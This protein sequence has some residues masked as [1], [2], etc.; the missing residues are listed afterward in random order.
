[1]A[2][3]G[4]QAEQTLQVDWDLVEERV[5]SRLPSDYKRLVEQFGKGTFD[6]G[7]IDLPL[8][9]ELVT[10]ARFH[11]DSGV[12]PW[13][14]NE[15]EMRLCWITDGADPDVWPVCVMGAGQLGTGDRFD[16][17]AT[18]LIVRMLTD[19]HHPYAVPIDY[20]SPWSADHTSHWFVPFGSPYRWESITPRPPGV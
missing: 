6:D 13:A 9:D 20:I 11:A 18:E 10:W 14:G 3:T 4:G 15:Q 12:L 1:M 2:A 8:P 5:G 19:P 7:Y 17:T 16:C